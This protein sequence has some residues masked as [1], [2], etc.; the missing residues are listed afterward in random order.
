MSRYSNITNNQRERFKGAMDKFC[1]FKWDDKDSWD[2]FSAFIITDKIGDLKTSSGPSFTNNYSKSQFEKTAGQLEG[3]TFNT[4][5]IS[6][7][8]GVYW[9]T[10]EEY[11]KFLNWLNPYQIADLQFSYD[12]EYAYFCKLAKIEDA[13]TYVVGEQKCL[14]TIAGKI[15]EVSEFIYYFETSLT[16]EIQG[17]AC[18]HKKYSYR[19]TE[20]DNVNEQD[21]VLDKDL[22]WHDNNIQIKDIVYKDYVSQPYYQIYNNEQSELDTSFKITLNGIADFKRI[23]QATIVK[24]GISYTW[25][26]EWNQLSTGKIKNYNLN[27]GSLDENNN[28][29]LLQNLFQLTFK[30]NISFHSFVNLILTYDS[31]QGLVFW[32][33]EDQL[34][35]LSYLTWWDGKK[36]VDS[37][38]VKK[39]ILPGSNTLEADYSH[40]YFQSLLTL[41]INL[42]QSVDKIIRND[43]Q[44][45]LNE[46]NET[47]LS[48]LSS[49]LNN[50]GLNMISGLE[51]FTSTFGTNLE[52][53]MYALRQII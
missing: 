31:Q 52:L 6:F 36:S 45:E 35:P 3:V 19:L 37:L 4:K 39:C 24:D 48:V 23:A 13:N 1:T 17:E 28:F 43:T 5:Q 44:S 20:I 22:T 16:F 11:R 42:D 34:I 46:N 12:R 33:N 40:F 38:S 30:D 47:Y 8:V 51:T 26:R 50:K 7:K 21:L 29:S 14:K 27:M 49:E 15:K 25:I 41:E 2:M 10:K 32:G 18:A 9:A 53:T